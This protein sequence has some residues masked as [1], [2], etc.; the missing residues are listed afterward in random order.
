MLRYMLFK[1]RTPNYVNETKATGIRHRDQGEPFY[2]IL[3][4]GK[5]CL[6]SP[7]MFFL[8]EPDIWEKFYVSTFKGGSHE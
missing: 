8:F 6:P 5:I 3:F 4:Y 1:N 2:M 7:I